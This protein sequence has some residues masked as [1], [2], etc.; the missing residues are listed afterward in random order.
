[1]PR[2][3]LLIALLFV[4]TVVDGRETKSERL[5]VPVER[6][7]LPISLETADG[8]PGAFGSRWRTFLDIFNESEE[9]VFVGQ[10]PELDCPFECPSQ[11]FNGRSP[12]SIIGAVGQP[13]TPAAFVYTS[14]PATGVVRFNLRVQDLSRQALTWGTELPVVRERDFTTTRMTLLSVPLHSRFRQTV[15]I[16]D[17]DANVGSRVIVRVKA[18]DSDLTLAEKEVV[19]AGGGIRNDEGRPLTPAYAQ[20][21]DL[22]A[23]FAGLDD[24]TSVRLEFEPLTPGLRIW[25]FVSI[26]NNE[27]QHVTTITP[28]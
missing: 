13:S 25:S 27:T 21:G 28:Q 3:I 11:F 8:I 15:R 12:V 4:A 26:T 6:L 2:S 16:Y 7:L 23:E 5:E 9:T 10:N 14:V 24:H 20:L 17:F 19:L 18:A 1:M 22:K